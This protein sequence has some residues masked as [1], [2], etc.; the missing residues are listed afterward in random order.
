MGTTNLPV[1]KPAERRVTKTEPLVSRWKRDSEEDTS[2]H[3][4][5]YVE[6]KRAVSDIKQVLRTA[7][8]PEEI[9][10]AIFGAD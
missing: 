10:K 5:G 1:P 9:Q 3:R 8:T 4:V 2:I 7:T 6:I